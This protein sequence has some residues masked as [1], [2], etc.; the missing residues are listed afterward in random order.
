MAGDHSVLLGLGVMAKDNASPKY[1]AGVPPSTWV[2]R[3]L[4]EDMT[5][6]QPVFRGL[7][8]VYENIQFHS[9]LGLVDSLFDL[10]LPYLEATV[11]MLLSYLTF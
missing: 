10:G 2:I 8:M 11:V 6:M 9:A 4:G 7:S 3:L 1:R 5:D